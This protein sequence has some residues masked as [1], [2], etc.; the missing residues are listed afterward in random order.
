MVLAIIMTSVIIVSA[1]FWDLFKFG[2]SG[3]GLEGELPTEK[4]TARVNITGAA[5]PPIIW[6]VSTP[7][8]TAL[9]AAQSSLH[10]FS[11]AACSIGGDTQLPDAG[12]VATRVNGTFIGTVGTVPNTIV[13]PVSCEYEGPIATP[14]ALVPNLCT[15]TSRN[16][17]CTVRM[18]YYY[19]S[20]TWRINASVRDDQ[21]RIAVNSSQTFILDS[22][23]AWT[24]S[25]PYVNWT[26]VELG[27]PKAS[28]NNITII[29]QGN[30]DI[31]NT[32]GSPL[33]INTTLLMLN[34]VDPTYNITGDK[35][36]A[37]SAIPYVNP[38]TAGTEL[39]TNNRVVVPFAIN[40]K[41]STPTGPINNTL[42]FCLE[43]LIGIPAGIYETS[44]LDEQ[45]WT[46]SAL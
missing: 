9:Y 30:Q 28:S 4:A 16:Y 19:D 11:F 10:K 42:Q 41:A 18:Y 46:I 45:R 12:E 6:F 37:S 33:D 2:K 26:S 31:N 14:G 17:S 24:R 36:N 5:A 20:G 1:G 29:L 43:G 3:E 39:S 22:L 38:C 15:S 13:P 23:A 44:S 27:A 35:F 25:P 34:G 40:H 8:S 7:N 21:G 32:A